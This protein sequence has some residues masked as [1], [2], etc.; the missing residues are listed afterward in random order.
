MA[1]GILVFVEVRDG[2]VKKPSLEALG[3]ARKLADTLQEPVTALLIG[4]PEIK[5]DLAHYGAEKV[6]A[7]CHDLLGFYSTEGFA[8]TL[9][10]ATRRVDAR[11]ILGS[12]TSTG[13]DFLPRAAAKMKVGLG[14]DCTEVRIVDGK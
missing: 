10:Q 13:R 1:Q 11:I 3:A 12:A 9:V 6:I 7:A 4:S 2:A 5:V 8:S 14:Q